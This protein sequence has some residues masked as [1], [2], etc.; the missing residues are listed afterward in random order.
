MKLRIGWLI[1]ITFTVGLLIFLFTRVVNLNDLQK[2]LQEANLVWLIPAVLAQA[3]A[4]ACS[5]LRWDVLLKGQGLRVPF[6]H[7]IS[8]FLVG[9]FLGTFLPSTIG[10]DAYRT[11][12]IASRTGETAKSIAVIL[13]EK[14]IGFFALFGLI[15]V[16]LPGGASLISSNLSIVLLVIFMLPVTVAFTLLLRPKWLMHLLRLPLPAKQ[17]IEPK[18][19]SAIEAVSL[20]HDQPRRLWT[21]TLLG[22]GV[23]LGAVMMY[24]F[25]SQ[26][27]G[28]DVTLGQML[29]VGPLIIIATVG[30]P[31]VGGEGAREGAA[32]VLLTNIVGQGKAFVTAHLGFWIGLSLS[33]PGGI[34]YALRPHDYR[35]DIIREEI[36]EKKALESTTHTQTEGATG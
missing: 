11:Y 14:I 15:V 17:R 19:R 25:N 7:L 18:L 1:R 30:L 26:V 12:D 5:I 2:E 9:R 24:Y 33:I 4:I 3:A 16:T 23:H 34:L 36:A 6:S 32:V 29:F 20:Y 27:F 10:L 28:V 22:V 31:V 8:T 21:A 35:P 13:V